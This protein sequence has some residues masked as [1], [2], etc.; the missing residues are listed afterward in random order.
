[1]RMVILG[2]ASSMILQVTTSAT[3]RWS[4]SITT[5][6]TIKIQIVAMMNLNTIGAISQAEVVRIYGSKE[7]KSKRKIA[8][9]L[10]KEAM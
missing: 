4:S 9:T 2:E 7:H 8:E 3:T 5:S 6:I 10:L 1:M